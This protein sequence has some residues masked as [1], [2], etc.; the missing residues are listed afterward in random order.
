MR[1]LRR[2]AALAAVVVLSG[3]LT[4]EEH[5]TFKKDGSGTMEYVLDMSEMGEMLDNMKGLTEEKDG[6]TT[7]D[8]GEQAAKLK[9]VDGIRKVKFKKEKKGYVQRISFR[10]KDV[11]ALNRALNVLMPD[12]SGVQQEFFRW[13]GSTLV[14][15]NNRHAEEIGGDMSGGPSAS[16]TTGI[17]DMLKS[18]HYKYSFTFAGDVKDVQLADGVTRETPKPNQ[19]ELATDWSVIMKDPKALDLRITLGK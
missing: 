2:L 5:Y 12:S 17:S 18:M 16:D 3:C 9:A 8:L 13:D 1:S 14:R 7:S 11:A 10:F 6:S 19:L 4:I 15:T